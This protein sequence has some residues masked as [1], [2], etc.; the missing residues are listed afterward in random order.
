V[1][2]TVQTVLLVEDDPA[3]AL[4]MRA[5]FDDVAPDVRVD[6]AETGPAALARLTEEPSPEAVVLDLNLPGMDGVEVLRAI[7]EDP[8]C[9]DLVVVVLSASVAERDR[10]AVAALGVAAH[11][12]KPTS[13]SELRALASDIT[14]GG[15]ASQPLPR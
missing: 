6:L 11:R 12:Q 14:G 4:L 13:Y 10:H 9:A 8:E 1:N 15:L 7:R 3:W 5:A 2:R